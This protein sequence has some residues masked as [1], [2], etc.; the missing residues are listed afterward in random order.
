MKGAG[1]EWPSCQVSPSTHVYVRTTCPCAH[2][3]T[4][5]SRSRFPPGVP[6]TPSLPTS[7]PPTGTVHLDA[8]TEAHTCIIIW[9][10][11]SSP[12]SQTVC[13]HEPGAGATNLLSRLYTLPTSHDPHLITAVVRGAQVGLTS[14]MSLWPCAGAARAHHLSQTLSSWR[15]S[16]RHPRR[17]DWPM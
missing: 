8:R 11:R 17:A 12:S 9:G 10:G 2:V 4:C 3:C 15:A 14:A 1:L 13:M 7:R 5:V 16:S 6:V